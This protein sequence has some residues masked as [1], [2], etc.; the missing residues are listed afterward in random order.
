LE[1]NGQNNSVL[2]GSPFNT[3]VTMTQ[4]IFSKIMPSLREPAQQAEKLNGSKLEKELRTKKKI[5]LN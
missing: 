5:I 3:A 2:D 1:E 4:S